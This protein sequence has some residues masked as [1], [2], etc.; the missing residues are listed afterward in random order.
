MGGS[1]NF[2]RVQQRADD[3]IT[4]GQERHGDE[5]LAPEGRFS[6]SVERLVDVMLGCQLSHETLRDPLFVRK[7]F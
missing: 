2:K 6:S 5:S 3:L 7:V 1:G 4:A